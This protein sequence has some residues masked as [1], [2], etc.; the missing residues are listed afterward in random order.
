MTVMCRNRPMVAGI[1]L[2]GDGNDGWE[3]GTR[4]GASC[5][6]AA[7]HRRHPQGTGGT[8]WGVSPRRGGTSPMSCGKLG[9]SVCC[10]CAHDNGASCLVRH[11]GRR[12]LTIVYIS[13]VR[14][15][16][17]PPAMT[18]ATGCEKRLV[19]AAVRIVR[20][21]YGD[22][23]DLSISVRTGEETNEDSVCSG[24]R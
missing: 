4:G 18:N 16:W 1:E 24:E 20:E 22:V 23:L 9:A 13:P 12:T 6:Q 5:A 14:D 3:T 17:A 10:D 21:A 11:R 15:R 2:A 19:T 8:D 7:T